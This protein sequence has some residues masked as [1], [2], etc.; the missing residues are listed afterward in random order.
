MLSSKKASPAPGSYSN[1]KKPLKVTGAMLD[2]FL[3]NN[4]P[5]STIE[6]A[7]AQL[8]NLT[9]GESGQA[10]LRQA[11]SFKRAAKT[12]SLIPIRFLVDTGSDVNIVSRDFIN[13][14]NLSGLMK[15]TSPKVITGACRDMTTQSTFTTKFTWRHKPDTDPRTDTFHVLENSTHDAILGRPF[16][17]DIEL[18]IMQDTTIWHSPVDDHRINKACISTP[19]KPRCM[20]SS[21]L[22]IYQS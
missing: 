7:L 16:W 18:H 12:P 15:R 8:K 19:W 5:A 20:T 17:N 21:P 13:R 11:I 6:T 14:N 3:V 2:G 9:S 22:F 4:V 10:D 1:D